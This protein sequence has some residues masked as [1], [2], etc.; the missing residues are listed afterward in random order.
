MARELTGN[1]AASALPQAG[2]LNA[3]L[4]GLP[5]HQQELIGLFHLDDLSLAETAQTLGIGVNTVKQRLLRARAAL[6]RQL[7]PAFASGELEELF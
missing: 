6:K 4:A 1:L 2:M 5:K 7:D 3:A